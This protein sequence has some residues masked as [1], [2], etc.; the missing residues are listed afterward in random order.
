VKREKYAMM[1]S[2][3]SRRCFFICPPGSTGK[4]AYYRVPVPVAE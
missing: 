1:L 3:E 2:T 4:G